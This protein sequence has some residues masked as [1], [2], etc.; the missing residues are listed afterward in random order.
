VVIFSRWRIR[1]APLSKTATPAPTPCLIKYYPPEYRNISGYGNNPQNPTW[2]VKSQPL[3]RS[4]V[5][6]GVGA[7]LIPVSGFFGS[8]STSPSKPGRA[9]YFFRAWIS[10]S[11]RPIHRPDPSLPRDDS[12]SCTIL[13]LDMLYLD[14][15]CIRWQ[16]QRNDFTPRRRTERKIDFKQGPSCQK[17]IEPTF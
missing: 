4:Q 8:P 3:V 16:R 7:L 1:L 11:A 10:W 9:R 13:I 14:A 6:F 17:N 5:R 12:Y 2:G 15:S